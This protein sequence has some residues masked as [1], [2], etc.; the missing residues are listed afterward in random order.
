VVVIGIVKSVL[1]PEKQASDNEKNTQHRKNQFC[2]HNQ[3][4]FV[5]F[6]LQV[7]ESLTIAFLAI[8]PWMERKMLWR[9]AGWLHSLSL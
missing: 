7:P 4:P 8:V 5:N 2:F 1:R 9:L 3:F 6:V